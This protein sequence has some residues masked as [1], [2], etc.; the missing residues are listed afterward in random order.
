MYAAHI[1]FVIA[2][3]IQ[4]PLQNGVVFHCIIAQVPKW[5]HQVRP[6]IQLKTFSAV[7]IALFLIVLKS[8]QHFR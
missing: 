4:G 7:M 5:C 3:S 6:T 1:T 8:V 2:Y